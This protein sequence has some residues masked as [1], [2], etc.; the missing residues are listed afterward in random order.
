M[1][2]QQTTI[3]YIVEHISKFKEY[4]NF[5]N[6]QANDFTGCTTCYLLFATCNPQLATH[7]L[8]PATYYLMPTTYQLLPAAY[9][10]LPVARREK[11]PFELIDPTT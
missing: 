4:F 1:V 5:T 11:L 2:N 8:R 10:P 7:H 9:C 3:Y 6:W